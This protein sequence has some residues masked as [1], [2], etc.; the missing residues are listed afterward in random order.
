MKR[1]DLVLDDILEPVFE[2][3]NAMVIVKS[4]QLGDAQEVN[5]PD[6]QIRMQASDRLVDLYGGQMNDKKEEEGLAD[7]IEDWR[8]CRGRM[9]VVDTEKLVGAMELL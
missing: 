9:P 7:L 8:S 4:Q 6:H 5:L 3:L 1:R 2:A